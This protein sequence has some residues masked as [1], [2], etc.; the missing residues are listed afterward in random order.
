MRDHD[1]T[2]TTPNPILIQFAKWPE[3]GRVKTRL[4]ESL[5]EEGALQAHI[6]LTLAVLGNLGQTA[7][8]LRLDWDRSVT[9]A[10]GEALPILER[11]QALRAEQGVQ[12]GQDLGER[13]ALA[14]SDGVKRQGAAII[15][16]SDC[17]SVD[18]D[19][20]NQ[21]RDALRTRDMVIGP[22]EDGGYV[23]IGSRRDCSGALEGIEW[24]TERALEQT[25]TRLE[26]AGFRVHC[27]EPRW[28]VDEA[29]DWERFL[30]AGAGSTG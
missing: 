29:A 9:E 12:Q 1:K 17:P 8:P 19:Y 23:L 27:L 15:V 22:S 30:N 26:Q 13:M 14:L 24:G 25:L 4:A 20:L 21:A 16:G 11:L 5:G 7:W 18:A 2:G 10:P 6:Q 28:D 3:L